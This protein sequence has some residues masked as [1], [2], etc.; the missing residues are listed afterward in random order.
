MPARR[1]GQGIRTGGAERNDAFLAP[2]V[3]WGTTPEED[4]ALL[5]DPQTSG[6][7]LVSVPALRVDEYLARVEGSV[8]IGE[9]APRGEHL[10]AVVG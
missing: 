3:D 2:L 6:G 10:I 5:V 9:V 7:L 8:V 1:C 4:R